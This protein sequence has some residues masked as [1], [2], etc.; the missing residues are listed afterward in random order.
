MSYADDETLF[1]VTDFLNQCRIELPGAADVAIRQRAYPV[2]HE[3]FN[4]SNAWT[5]QIA[6]T[7]VANQQDY[8][9]TPAEIPPGQVIRLGG[10]FDTNLIN[11]PADMPKI[12]LLEFITTPTQVQSLTV[13]AIKTVLRPS[14][15]DGSLDH[16]YPLPGIPSWVWGQ[17]LPVF[18]HGVVGYMMMEKNRP[19]S[20]E[21]MGLFHLQMYRDGVKMARVAALRRNTFGANAWMY[22]Q[23]MRV[24][25]Q[26]GGISVGNEVRF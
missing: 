17:Y 4:Y 12:G 15:A 10:V 25:G 18:V 22:P 26:R 3:F 24:R 2:L 11:Y 1:Y 23:Q 8:T 13:V 16:T 6:L 5:E 9:L 20:D 19:Y 14:N 7:T 21:K